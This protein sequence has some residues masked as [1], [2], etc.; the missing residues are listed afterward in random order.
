MSKGIYCY[1]DLQNNDSIVY[2]GKDSDIG[3]NE[4]HKHHTAPSHYD[5]QHIN[6]VV[7]NNPKRYKYEVLCENDH[8]S[9]VYLKSLE[10]GLIKVY[11]PL[12]NFTKGG[13]GANMGKNHFAWKDYPR[14]K[15]NGHHEGKQ[16]YAI[17]YNG[18][19]IKQSIFLDKLEKELDLL[20]N[21]VN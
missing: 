19:V 1:I 9:D 11:N 13:D 16:L 21:E 3:R 10:K 5:T 20:I 7:Q 12:F 18:K 15:K 4:R 6:R 17:K 14:I 8:Y 2:I